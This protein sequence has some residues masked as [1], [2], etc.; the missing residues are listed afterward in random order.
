MPSTSL[1]MRSSTSAVRSMIAS[2]RPT[3]IAGVVVNPAPGL[4]A[5]LNELAD[6]AE[7]A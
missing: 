4:E 6:G 2:M 1:L 7:V 5:R 3:K